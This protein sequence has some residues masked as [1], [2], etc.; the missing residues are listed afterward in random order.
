MPTMDLIKKLCVQSVSQE[1]FTIRR[2]V[3]VWFHVCANDNLLI[4]SCGSVTIAF[5][6]KDILSATTHR[7]HLHST[8]QVHKDV[9]NGTSLV[10]GAHME[11]VN[12]RSQ[13]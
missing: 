9:N 6:S 8:T 4:K 3:F 11:I 13:L 10:N 7:F 12:L 2:F 5:A 1:V